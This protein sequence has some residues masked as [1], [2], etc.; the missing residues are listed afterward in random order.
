MADKLAE[1]FVELKLKVDELE[2]GL[3]RAENDT[4]KSV[5]SMVKTAGKL[6]AAFAAVGVAIG[7]AIGK[8]SL[9]LF[10]EQEK[11][12]AKLAAVIKATGSAANLTAQEM[13]NMA[14]NMQKVTTFGDE[15][16]IQ[17]QAILATFKNIKG[18][19]FERTTE[20]VL[21][22]ATVMGTDLKSAA[23]QL[24]KAL[25]DPAVG[26]SM[27][28]RSGITFSETQKEMVKQLAKSG[29]MLGAQNIILQEVES[30]F[31]GAAKAAAEKKDD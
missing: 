20:A 19:Q 18:D 3:K 4:K 31:G 2:K 30:Q 14:S 17:G 8:K 22:M 15:V 21:D 5:G 11:A 12:E 26:M 9:A 25:N 1:A 23:I 7:A 27:L 29:D 24:G 13:F 28:T 10:I 6:T 16:V